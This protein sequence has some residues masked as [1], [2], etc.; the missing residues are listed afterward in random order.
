MTGGTKTTGRGTEKRGRPKRA[1]VEAG[2]GSTKV[3][4]RRRAGKESAATAERETGR[5]MENS[6][7]TNVVVA[8]RGAI[9]SESPVMTIVSIVV[10]EGVRAL[11]KW[12]LTAILLLLLLCSSSFFSTQLSGLSLVLKRRNVRTSGVVVFGHCNVAL[13]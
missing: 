13:R 4:E 1:G 5:E 10:A 2:R 7:L 3:G 6:V 12:R 11:S 8:K 9:I